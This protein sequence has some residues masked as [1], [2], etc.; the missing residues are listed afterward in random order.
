MADIQVDTAPLRARD[1]AFQ[2]A[3]AEP[4]NDDGR[5][6]AERIGA[7]DG[8]CTTDSRGCAAY[9]VWEYRLLRAIFDDE[10]GELARDYVGS[11]PSWV[12]LEGLLQDPGASW[13]DDTTTPEVETADVV[14]LTALDA[15][16]AELAAGLGAP[17]RWTWG[18]LH[19]ATFRE[20]TV[21][22][23]GIGPLEWYMNA[24]AVAV[25]GAAGAVNNT[26]YRLSRGYPDPD[27]PGAEPADITELF[28]VT[29]LPSYR[30]VIDMSDM[31]GAGIVITTGQGGNPLGR[32]IDDQIEVWRD[33]DLLPFP[34]TPEA[35][36][37]ATVATLR[38]K[39]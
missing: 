23:S 3:G 8:I 1:I 35:V 19:T 36:D 15:A 25:D 29:S 12:A 31:D 4:A 5:L 7:W 37:A 6:V 26:Y 30:L 9:M 22:S 28:T 16:G 39:P 20:D 32:H 10:L 34:F 21:G 33:G 27:D 38:L 17:D 24:G 11:P 2:L 13:W 14:I 18:A